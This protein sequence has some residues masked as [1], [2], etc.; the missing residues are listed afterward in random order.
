MG[1]LREVRE[2]HGGIDHRPVLLTMSTY[3]SCESTL[4]R[5]NYKEADC[6]L[7]SQLTD[8]V[9]KH[10]RVEGRDTNTVVKYFNAGIL[11]AA[12]K[13]IPRVARQNYKPY[14][15]EELERLDEE[16]SAARREA[17][18]NPSQDNH[19]HLQHTKARF[20]RYKLQAR[21]KSWRN[22]TASLNLEKDGTKLWRLTKQLND[23][24]NGRATTTLEADGQLLSGKQAANQFAGSYEEV[25]N[26]PVTRQHQREARREQR[27]RETHQ[28]TNECM[29]KKLT[30]NELQAALRQLKAKKSPG[31][32]TITNEML[33]HLGKKAN[34]QTPGDLQPQ[35]GNRH[36]RTN[37]E[38]SNNDPNP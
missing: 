15:S 26:I 17:E 21:R 12:Q 6:A 4:P 11:T 31:T 7:Y 14:W 19:N 2:Q 3:I 18:T 29:D 30:L 10:I 13:C 25:S 22:K 33:T 35:L 1:K 5:W 36:T 28:T 38:G 9:T 37:M 34:L 32:D 16:L 27:E 20:L 8:Q 24:G 23:E